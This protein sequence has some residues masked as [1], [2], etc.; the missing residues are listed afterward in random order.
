MHSTFLWAITDI[1][2]RG[3]IKRTQYMSRG[4]R[5]RVGATLQSAGAACRSEERGLLE[6][7]RPPA[8]ADEFHAKGFGGGGRGEG[9]FRQGGAGLAEEAFLTYYSPS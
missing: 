6:T 3:S 5:T 2:W 7:L 9:R 8:G 4:L 1:L